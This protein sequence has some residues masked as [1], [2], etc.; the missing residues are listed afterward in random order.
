MSLLYRDSGLTGQWALFTFIMLATLGWFM[1][2]S[3][4]AQTRIIPTVSVTETY[5]SNVFYTPKSLLQPGTQPEDFITQITPQINVAQLGSRVR[6]SFAVG[7]IVSMYAHNS[8][9]NY[10]GLNATGRLD[11]KNYADRISQRIVSFGLFGTYQFTPSVTSF[12]ATG[13][14]IGAGAGATTIT[15]PLNVGQVTNRVY[16]HNLN[17]GV[18]AGYLLTRTT[19]VSGSYNYSKIHFSGQSGGVENQLFDTDGHQATMT[20]ANQLS[21]RDTVGTTARMSH[22]DQ[23]GNT[24]G[25]SSFTTFNGTLNWDRKWTPTLSTTL[26]GGGVMTMPIDSTGAGQRVPLQVAPAITANLNYVTFSEGLRAAG[27]A[28]PAPFDGLPALEGT[29]MPGGIM[30]PGQFGTRLSY[31]YNVYPSFVI[32]SGPMK[33]HIAGAN[34]TGGI[35]SKLSGQLGLN[36]SHGSTSDP[37][38]TFDSVNASVGASYLIGPVLANLTYRWMYFSNMNEQPTGIEDQ[39]AFSKKMVML[40]L[41]Y[42]FTNQ[43]FFRMGGLGSF[44]TSGTAAPAE[45]G[46]PSDAGPGAIPSGGGTLLGPGK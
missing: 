2:M 17:F 36:Y 7:G 35:T 40:T 29:L 12:G 23:Q 16:T 3:A 44:G 27:A 13:G 39:Y 15:S 21:L 38:S 25:S 22:F 37:Q 33:T 6:S 42:A 1:N 18:N 4:F 46:T 45:G 41:S 20:I 8:N 34:I 31:N 43:S 5:D 14:G 19:T 24:G 30:P 32:G 10:T 28:A 11:L 26:M 9:L